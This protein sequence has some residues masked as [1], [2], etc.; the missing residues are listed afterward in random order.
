MALNGAS[1]G[2]DITGSRKVEASVPALSQERRT[3]PLRSESAVLL[4]T[5][6]RN[7]AACRQPYCRSSQ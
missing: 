5:S 4:H 2:V 1:S 7:R 3:P 6:A